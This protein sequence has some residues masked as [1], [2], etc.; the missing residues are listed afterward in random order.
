MIHAGPELRFRRCST[1]I[2]I[3]TRELVHL[4]WHR[5]P[6][7]Q[8]STS[9]TEGSVRSGSD[10]Q[11]PR[12]QN[13]VVRL[14]G[15]KVIP[16]WQSCPFSKKRLMLSTVLGSKENPKSMG[17]ETACA[18][19]TIVVDF[20]PSS[21]VTLCSVFAW[22]LLLPDAFSCARATVI[23]LTARSSVPNALDNRRRKYCSA[24]RVTLT[25]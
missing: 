7:Y 3:R 23:W 20:C 11:F 10:T 1:Y 9:S 12:L 13:D 5:E 6:T 8:C 17:S 21:K 22:I 25:V 4:K 18:P 14:P 15:C 2:T 24:P 19:P 16:V